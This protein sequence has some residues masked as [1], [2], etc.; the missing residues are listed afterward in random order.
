MSEERE[1][2]VTNKAKGMEN[3][4]IVELEPHE[5]NNDPVMTSIG[6]NDHNNA[7]EGTNLAE[8]TPNEAANKE[9]TGRRWRRITTQRDFSNKEYCTEDARG[10]S[11]G[12]AMLWTEDVEVTLRKM[13]DRVIDVMVKEES[14]FTWRLTGM[15]AN[16]YPYTWSNKR[17]GDDLIEE[18][19]DRVLANGEW[20]A[21]FSQADVTNMIWDC[22][23]HTP[24]V[25]KLKGENR[26]PPHTTQS[27]VFWFEAKWL[28]VDCFEEKM[29]NFLNE[30]LEGGQ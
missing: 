17:S 11:G 22:S 2:E 29:H 26:Q 27:R 28:Q 20:R 30:A 19:L 3:H 9:T 16:G 15:Y 6:Y 25:L 4:S 7:Q 23:D 13:G 12:L 5:L 10:R 18:R 14:N 24:I 8:R 21:E 1:N